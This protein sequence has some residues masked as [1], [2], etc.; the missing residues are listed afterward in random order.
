MKILHFLGTNATRGVASIVQYLAKYHTLEGHQVDLISLYKSPHKLDHSGRFESMG[1]RVFTSSTDHRYSPLQLFRLL[2]IMRQYDI[3]HVHQ[4]PAQMWGALAAL[5]SKRGGYPRI[6]TTEHSTFNNRRRYPALRLFDRFM[7]RQYD[8]IVCISD[9]TRRNLSDWLGPAYLIDRIITITNGIDYSHF[10]DAERQSPIGVKIEPDVKYIGWV[11]LLQ[12]PKTPITFLKALTLL[13]EE[14]HA[15]LIGDGAYMKECIDYISSHNLWHRVHMLGNVTDVSGI[16]KCCM[17]SVLSTDWEGFGLAAAEAMA[18]GVPV[19]AS[20][21]PGLRDVVG[22]ESLLFKQPDHTDLAKKLRT[23]LYDEE[24]YQTA[25][26]HSLT[27]VRSF[28]ASRMAS[29]YLTLYSTLLNK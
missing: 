3:V 26:D 22:H 25:V 21:V 5:L 2:R 9:A 11:G 8:R 17:V 10:A 14:C 20:D 28:S 24:A 18:S 15:I 4:F 29:S 6:I 13:P 23:L 19:I 27:H 16:I 1:C 12:Q 7:Y